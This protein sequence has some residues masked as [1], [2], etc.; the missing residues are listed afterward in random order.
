VRKYY[1]FSP[2]LLAFLFVL[3]QGLNAQ[4][5]YIKIAGDPSI[6]KSWCDIYL[7]G[8]GSV[9]KQ[10]TMVPSN[11]FTLLPC[12]DTSTRHQI[13]LDIAN[14]KLKTFTSL[15]GFYHCGDSI[16]VDLVHGNAFVLNRKE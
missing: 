11:N 12:T 4:S 7:T 10:N 9:Y 13:I 16:V 2:C 14:K 3:Q 5:I 8:K 6:T 15:P 1:L